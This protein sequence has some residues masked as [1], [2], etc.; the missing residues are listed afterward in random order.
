MRSK[1]RVLQSGDANITQTFHYSGAKDSHGRYW[2]YYHGGIDLVKNDHYLDY[3]VAHTAGTVVG[4]RTNCTG[5]EGGGSYGNYVMLKHKNG[6]YTLYAH[7]AHGTV[8]VKLNQKVKKGEVLAYM[9]NTGTSYGG[10]LHFEVR[11]KQNAKVD[12]EPFLNR[13]LPGMTKVTFRSYDLKKKKW[14]PE[15][16]NGTVGTNSAG[17]A[18]N[19]IGAITI[20]SPKMKGYCA[21]RRGKKGWG[22][23]ITAYGTDPYQYVGNKKRAIMKLAIDAKDIAYRGQYTDGTW[24]PV[25]FGKNYSLTDPAGY[26]GDGK[27]PLSQV[28]CWIV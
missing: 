10:H 5:F 13:D 25:R 11:N 9:D 2:D 12:P 19:K 17:N 18:G 20:K 7:L 27:R 26:I 15:V 14:L 23:Y 28:I 1:C 8:K 21:V 22:N 24:T 6:Y 16:K 3:I 4:I